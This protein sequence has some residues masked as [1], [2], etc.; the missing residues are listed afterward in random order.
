MNP[1]GVKFLGPLPPQ[2]LIMFERVIYP[3][4]GWIV[5]QK[6][7][8]PNWEVE[9]V[10]YIPLRKLLV[11]SN[12]ACYRL[13]IQSRHATEENSIIK[14]FPC[15]LYEHNDSVEKLWG[16]TFRITMVFLEIVFGFKPPDIESLPV[17]HGAL[18]EN[19][20]TGNG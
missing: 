7:F 6:R 15:F 4:V 18:D 10:L 19:Y 17:I 13:N 1:F 20:L 9:K 12:Y 16:A 5:G 8:T 2:K 3:M 14:D 11:P